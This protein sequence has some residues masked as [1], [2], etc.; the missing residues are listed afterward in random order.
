MKEQQDENAPIKLTISE[1]TAAAFKDDQQQQQ[2]Q[3]QLK[4]SPA[5][6]NTT[7]SLLRGEV[8]RTKDGSSQLLV[9]PD[10]PG[11]EQRPT[12]GA[13]QQQHAQ[14]SKQLKG[15]NIGE[16]GGKTLRSH[17]SVKSTLPRNNNNSRP[18]RVQQPKTGN[19]FL[20]ILAGASLM[21]V[22]LAFVLLV[23]TI[24]QK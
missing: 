22:L 12:T 2:Q 15:S 14:Q 6:T 19:V 8:P 23:L 10:G 1:L 24:L 3:Q 20:Y 11:V 21:L 5:S 18:A 9:V 13:K 7:A 16:P 4:P 17:S